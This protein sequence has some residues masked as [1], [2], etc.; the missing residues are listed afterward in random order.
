MVG[1]PAAPQIDRPPNFVRPE[2]KIPLERGAVEVGK[3]GH[4]RDRAVPLQPRDFGI[5]R[6]VPATLAQ[7]Q[8]A[9]VYLSQ[10]L[11][12]LRRDMRPGCALVQN[13][14]NQRNFLLNQGIDMSQRIGGL[15]PGNAG[16]DPIEIDPVERGVMLVQRVARAPRNPDRDGDGDNERQHREQDRVRDSHGSEFCT[17]KPKTSRALARRFKTL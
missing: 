2:R 17:R 14:P 15:D 13:L 10:L 8:P 1:G 3:V 12:V 16:S 5:E 4:H 6:G 9:P 11:D 7:R